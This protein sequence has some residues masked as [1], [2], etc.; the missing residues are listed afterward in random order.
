MEG[1]LKCMDMYKCKAAESELKS[2]PVSCHVHLH[3]VQFKQQHSSL[4]RGSYVVF[5]CWLPCFCC[6]PVLC[7]INNSFYVQMSK[8][9]DRTFRR[10]W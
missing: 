7:P 5:G 10:W 2:S 6:L 9:P 4:L 1:D 3:L 8:C